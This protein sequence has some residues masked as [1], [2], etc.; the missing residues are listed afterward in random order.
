MKFADLRKNL[1]KDASGFPSVRIAVLGDTPTQFLHQA[2]KGCAYERGLNTVIFE[3]GFNEVEA[4]VLGLKSDLY[5]F[6][7]EFV[8]VFESTQRLLSR[9]YAV[10]RDS[11]SSFATAH[12]QHVAALCQAVDSRPGTRLIYCNFTE[13]DDSVYGNF[14]NKT[15]LS[16]SYQVRAVNLGLMNLAVTT[17]NL[18]IAD[19]SS[20]QND[21]GRR[22]IVSTAMYATAGLAYTLDFWPAI[23]GRVL[24]IIAAVRGRIHKA[25]VLDL[26]NTLWGGVVG[27]DGLEN[28]QIGDLGIG[29]AFSDL[30]AWLK[31]LKQRGILLAVCSKNYEDVARGVFRDHPDMILRLDDIAVFV[32]NWENKVDNLRHIQSVLNIGFDSMVYLDDSPFEREM[33]KEAIPSLTVPDLPEDP[34]DY[35]EVLRSLNL[36]ETASFSD[37]DETRTHQYLEE[38]RRASIQKTYESENAFL[39]SLKMIARARP[40]DAFHVPRIAQLSQRSNQFNLRTVRYT[41]RDVERLMSDPD[42]VTLYFTL[43]DRVGDYGL[44]SLVVLQKRDDCLFIENWLMSC[45]VLKRGME[46]LV[47]NTMMRAAAESGYERLVGEYVPTEK[48][49]LVRDHYAKLGFT[50]ERG[51]WVIDAERYRARPTPICEATEPGDSTGPSAANAG[52]AAASG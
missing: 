16:F 3:A 20:L 35:L 25:V 43:E 34:A 4:Q 27:D 6:A 10:P 11:Q 36:F 39:A 49:G 28:I 42:Y 9:F 37:A 47:L 46:E 41:E 31:Q 48:N 26:D 32:A 19:L 7:P 40:F 14:A 23:A 21:L 12:V 15:R 51:M 24:D 2:L 38:S 29:K 22:S 1:K 45:R 50:P 17:P 8:L 18:M 30:Q 5:A 13:L 44:V 52:A 33:V